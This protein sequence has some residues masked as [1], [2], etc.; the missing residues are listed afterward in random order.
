MLEQKCTLIEASEGLK[1]GMFVFIKGYKNEEGEK[2]DITVHADAS[3]DSVYQRSADK[4]TAIEKDP[5]FKLELVR[6]AWV[7]AK[8]VE[9]ALKGKKTDNRTQKVGIKETITHADKDWSEAVAKVRKG[10]VDPKTITDNMEKVGNS[11]YDNSVT[12]KTYL[13]NVLIHSK[14]ICLDE[15]G[16]PIKGDYPVKCGERVNAIAKAIRGMLPIGQYRTYILEDGR[17]DSVSLMGESISSS[18]SEE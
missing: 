10:I 15:N 13:R 5:N 2:A 11:V 12:G 4:L 3:Y 18:S 17:F 16:K 1:R 8:G 14:V 6:N 9:Y 7:D